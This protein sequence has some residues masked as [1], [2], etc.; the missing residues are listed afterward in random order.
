MAVPYGTVAI[1]KVPGGWKWTKDGKDKALAWAKNHA[2]NLIRTKTTED[3]PFEGI[4]TLLDAKVG[5]RVEALY[6]ETSPQ[7]VRDLAAVVEFAP[8]R[9]TV[10]IK[11]GVGK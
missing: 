11:T 2:I 8:D 1:R 9:E 7:H 4:Q 10:T 5:N 6:D 3:V